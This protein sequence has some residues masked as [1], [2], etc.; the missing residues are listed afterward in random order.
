MTITTHHAYPETTPLAVMGR[1]YYATTP[2]AWSGTGTIAQAIAGTI[3][4]CPDAVILRV[5]GSDN[6]PAYLPGGLG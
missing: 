5:T 3:R 6:Q 2:V 4:Q 1:D